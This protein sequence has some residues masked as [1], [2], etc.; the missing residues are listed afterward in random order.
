MKIGDARQIYSGQI[1]EFWNKKLSLAKQKKELEAKAPMMGNE[2]YANEAATLELS[3][4]AVTEKYNE[5]HDFM[6]KIMN[7]HTA[8]FNAEVSR[9]QSETMA[10]YGE[11]MAKIMEVARRIAQGGR[12]PAADEKKLMEFSME[13][14]MA[15]KNMAALHELKERKDYDSLWEEE[16]NPTQNPDPNEIANDAELSLDGPEVMDVDDVIASAAA[17]ADSAIS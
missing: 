13:M 5:Y 8:Y 17:P 1:H 16:E 3:Y 14:Y 9:Q 10:E 7:I 12:V 2:A 4:N 15:A 11:D 6:E